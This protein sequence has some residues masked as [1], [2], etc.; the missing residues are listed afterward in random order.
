[1]PC[2]HGTTLC[3]KNDAA[4]LFFVLLQFHLS[5]F[6]RMLFHCD[7]NVDVP[8]LLTWKLTIVPLLLL[9]FCD[10]YFSL[11]FFNFLFYLNPPKLPSVARLSS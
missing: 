9:S 2:R 11:F 1:M 3:S 6:T 5:N 8:L 4:Y 10:E 7:G